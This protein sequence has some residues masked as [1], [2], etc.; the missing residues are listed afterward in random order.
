VSDSAVYVYGIVAAGKGRPSVNTRGVEAARIRTIENDGLLALI[1]DVRGESLAAAREVRAHWRV[2]DE[3]SESATVLPVRFG[4]LLEDEDAVRA[5]LLEPNAQQLKELLRELD[6]RVQLTLKG[7]YDEQLLLRQVVEES[8]AV[9]GL[10]DRLRSVPA[11]AAYYERIRLGE[12]VAAHVD[13]RR[14]EDTRLALEMLEP[15]AVATREEDPTRPDAALSLSFLVE[16]DRLPAFNDGVRK[17]GERFGDRIS[18]RY[19]G[20]L[21]PYSFADIQLDAEAAAWA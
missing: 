2:L 9:A 4:T 15:L 3:A 18:L 7:D 12:L 20:P 14:A 1:S 17:L 21:P 10:R 8:A 5:Q 19:V 6:G 13:Q 16:R 11:E